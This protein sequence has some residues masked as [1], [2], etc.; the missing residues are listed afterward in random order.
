M[1]YEGLKAT[2]IIELQ[3]Q[4]L[5]SSSHLQTL[6]VSGPKS[7]TIRL[8]DR[9]FECLADY[10]RA[11]T[12]WQNR[13]DLDSP[14]TYRWIFVA[15]KGKDQFLTLPHLTRHGL[16]FMLHELGQKTGINH[17]HTESLRHHAI[18]FQLSLGH[19]PEDIMQHLGLRRLGNVGKHLACLRG[20][21]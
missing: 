18:A 6:T 3:W 19:G 12:C 16:K 2:E 11:F 1:A 7:R 9:T 13:Q 8:Q 10:V 4:D 21:L 20:L 5:I 15:F 14:A 17:L